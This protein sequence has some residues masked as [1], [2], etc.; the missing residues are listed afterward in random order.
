MATQK[1]KALAKK[2]LENPTSVDITSAEM[3]EVG[4][5]PNTRPSEIVNSKGWQMLLEKHLPDDKLLTKHEEALEATKVVSARIIG[6]DADS[7][8][9]DFIDVPDYPTRL[10]AVELGYKVKGKY[11]ETPP[12]VNNI[13]VL[14]AELIGK[15]GITPNTEAGSSGQS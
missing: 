6:K 5:S 2:I 9:D 8:T 4:Y 11:I 14:P 1:Q 7:R 15:Y 3:Q 12:S 13:L 10:K